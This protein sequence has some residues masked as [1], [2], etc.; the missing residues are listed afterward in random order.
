MIE[1]NEYGYCSLIK[2][3]DRVLDKLDVYNT[4]HTKISGKAQRDEWRNVNKRALREAVINAI[5][6][7]DYATNEVP[8]VFEIFSDRL[9]I[10]SM[11][12]IPLGMTE[13]E[14]FKG[15]SKPRNKVLMRI[16]KD[17]DFVEQLGSGMERILSVYDRSIFEISDN[18]IRVT[19][20]FNTLPSDSVG[21]SSD[22]V[23]KLV[24]N[25]DYVESIIKYAEEHGEFKSKQIQELLGLQESRTREI[26]SKLCKE[27]VLI[28]RGSGRNTY[29]TKG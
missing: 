15:V 14:F 4:T 1:R 23:G 27:G 17:M 5:V 16:F 26:I 18:F 2:A 25:N 21:K 3:V 12:G 20:M 8:P 22:S 13:E 19:F 28:R 6:H 10:T 11:G 9:V 7:N 24:A 29:Y